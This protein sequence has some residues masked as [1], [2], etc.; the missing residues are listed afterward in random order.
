MVLDDTALDSIESFSLIDPGLFAQVRVDMACL[1]ILI[2]PMLHLWEKFPP[3]I[4]SLRFV[5]ALQGG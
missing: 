5:L 2:E 4:V 3:S 1:E